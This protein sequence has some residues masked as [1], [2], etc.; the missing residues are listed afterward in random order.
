MR[1]GMN[2]G[3]GNLTGAVRGVPHACGDEPADKWEGIFDIKCSPCVW[4]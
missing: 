3:Q 1:V 2:R 4:G